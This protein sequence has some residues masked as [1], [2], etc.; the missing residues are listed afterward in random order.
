MHGHSARASVA[1]RSGGSRSRRSRASARPSPRSRRWRRRSLSSPRRARCSSWSAS[2][3]RSRT[4]TRDAWLDRLYEAHQNDEIPYIESLADHWGDLC[5]T[6]ELASRWADRLIGI[7]SNA[8]SLDPKMR[9]HYHGTTMCL[10]ALYRAER[11]EELLTLLEPEKFW[12]YKRWSVRALAALGKNS[13]AIKL[14]GITRTVDERARRRA[15]LRGDLAVVGARGRGVRTLFGRREPRRDVPCDI[16][17]GGRSRSRGASWRSSGW[18][19]A[20]GT[21]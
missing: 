20:T 2:R 21:K 19:R 4:W 3:R 10:T 1:T 15:A 7:T 9:G 16:P 5:V 13:E 6:K 12:R 14:R 18:R 17:R 8:L 11:F